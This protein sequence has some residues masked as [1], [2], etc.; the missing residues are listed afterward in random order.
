MKKRNFTA[1]KLL[2][3]AASHCLHQQSTHFHPFTLSHLLTLLEWLKHMV[4]AFNQLPF[5]LIKKKKK[6]I[7]FVMIKV[8]IEVK[9][10]FYI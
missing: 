2:S 10:N 8:L 4:V 7:P 3:E 1:Q 6:Q 5:V 9:S